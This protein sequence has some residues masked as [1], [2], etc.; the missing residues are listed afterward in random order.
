MTKK[1]RVV[2]WD[3]ETGTNVYMKRKA[4]PFDPT[5]YVVASGWKNLGEDGI[6]GEYF[7]TNKHPF[8]WFT[9]C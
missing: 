9:T 1:A 7:S 4:S 2:I 8:D 3:V 5:N 6:Q